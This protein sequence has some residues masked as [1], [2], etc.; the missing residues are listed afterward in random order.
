M[1]NPKGTRFETVLVRAFL[2]A[3]FPAERKR[4]RGSDDEGDFHVDVTPYHSLAVEARDRGVM[5]PGVAV[6]KA[7]KEAQSAQ[8]SSL[9]AI[10][11]RRYYPVAILKRRGHNVLDS[12]AVIPIS[13]LIE[14]IKELRIL[15][16]ND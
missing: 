10:E 13:T 11:Q 16:G 7:V 5:S 9:N 8:A 6:D 1:S 15:Y 2:E 12:Y 3:G 14:I 4:L